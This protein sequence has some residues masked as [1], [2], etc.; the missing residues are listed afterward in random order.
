MEHVKRSML[1]DVPSNPDVAPHDHGSRIHPRI[2]SP[3][4]WHFKNTQSFRNSGAEQRQGCTDVKR[5]A[6]QVLS[7]Q[8]RSDRDPSYLLPD[9]N[10]IWE[11]AENQ[12][13]MQET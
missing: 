11:R 12:T 9:L 1:K 5:T 8:L 7:R 13:N 4:T 2:E 10:R 6:A 3:P